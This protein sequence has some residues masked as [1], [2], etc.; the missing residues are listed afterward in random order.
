MGAGIKAF[1]QDD[2]IALA[3][4]L[5]PDDY[6]GPLRDPGPGFEL[7]QA[8]AKVWAEI[9]SSIVGFDAGLYILSAPLAA[10]SKGTV[11]VGRLTSAAGAVL[12]KAGSVVSASVYERRYL[13]L[14]DLSFG[15]TD[16]GPFQVAVEAEDAGAE[17]DL[18]GPVTDAAGRVLPG[19]IDLMARALQADPASP[20]LLTFIENGWTVAQDAPTTGGVAGALEALGADRGQAHDAGESAAK[21]RLR[22]RRLPDVVTPNA[23]QRA[24]SKL[25]ATCGATAQVVEPG[26]DDAMGGCWNAPDGSGGEFMWNDP[27]D[28]MHVRWLDD[29]AIEGAFMLVLPLV[30]PVT[31]RGGAWNDPATQAADVTFPATDGYRA[32]MCWNAPDDDPAAGVHF[33]CWSGGD[34]GADALYAGGVALLDRVKAGGVTQVPWLA[35]Q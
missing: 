23:L 19:Q 26:H 27:R 32:F 4:R 5:L 13:T 25:A 30:Q 34:S 22:L 9:S 12:L 8:Y 16:L 17:Y 11:L 31:E 21:Y 35:G 33:A 6:T 2:L 29:K 3:L 15:S 10:R 1:T 18:P 7:I 24:A 14:A 20:D 28:G